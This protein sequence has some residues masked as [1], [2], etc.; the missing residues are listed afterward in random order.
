[1]PA[2]VGSLLCGCVLQLSS[3]RS[4]WRSSLG[5]PLTPVIFEMLTMIF[6]VLHSDI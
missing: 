4:C 5:E 2:S 1:M 3:V 6:E